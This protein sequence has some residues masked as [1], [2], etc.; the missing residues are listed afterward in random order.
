MMATEDK[1]SGTNLVDFQHQMLDL[2][3][4]SLKVMPML[5][6]LHEIVIENTPYDVVFE[7][8]RASCRERV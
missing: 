3:M 7:I 8:G 2:Y 4:G 1:P 5:S 6:N